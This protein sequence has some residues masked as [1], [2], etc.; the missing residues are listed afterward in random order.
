MI[1]GGNPMEKRSAF[2]HPTMS[3]WRKVVILM[4]KVTFLPEA[5]CSVKRQ[6]KAWFETNY[7]F[8]IYM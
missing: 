2:R 5:F 6:T 7:Y 8:Q 3:P 4:F 1:S